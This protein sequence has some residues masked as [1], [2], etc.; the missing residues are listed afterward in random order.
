VVVAPCDT[1]ERNIV[2]VVAS[3]DTMQDVKTQSLHQQC[4]RFAIVARSC[5]ATLKFGWLLLGAISRS[6]VVIKHL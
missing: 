6:L 2:V 4:C 5:N 3:W 1:T